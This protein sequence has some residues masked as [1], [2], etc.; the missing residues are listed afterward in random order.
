MVRAVALVP[1]VVACE[2]RASEDVASALEE[3]LLPITILP[4]ACAEVGNKALTLPD[5]ATELFPN[6]V[7]NEPAAKL[8]VPLD[9]TLFPIATAL[10]PVAEGAVG[11][12]GFSA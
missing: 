8:L 1:A 10:V 4:A 12:D 5:I 9:V 6:A 7:V 2:P 11:L 3:A